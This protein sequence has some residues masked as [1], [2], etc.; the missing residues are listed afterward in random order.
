V[1]AAR[2][3]LEEVLD[4]V[5]AA[6]KAVIY[7]DVKRS[8]GSYHACGFSIERRANDGAPAVVVPK[9]QVV[10]AKVCS[11][12]QVGSDFHPTAH[13]AGPATDITLLTLGASVEWHAVRA[14]TK[15]ALT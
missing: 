10:G 9:F 12:L 5:E 3:A 1:Q 4:L 7:V 11:F 6:R 15:L 2:S 13:E 14:T 8:N